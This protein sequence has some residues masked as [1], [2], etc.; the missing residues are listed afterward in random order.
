MVDDPRVDHDPEREESDRRSARDREARFP[1]EFDRPNAVSLFL[2]LGYD[3]TNNEDVVR[4]ASDLRWASEQ[5]KL[6]NE[7]L[8]HR[9]AFLVSGTIAVVSVALTVLGQWVVNKLTG[10][11]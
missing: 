2:R 6:V 7:Q 5:R 4:L 11:G 10:R 1:R 3:I 8:T 9:T